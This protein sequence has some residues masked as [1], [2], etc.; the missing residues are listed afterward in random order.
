MSTSP[1]RGATVHDLVGIGFG[2][3]NLALAIAIE[4]H[5]RAAPQHALDAVFLERQ[6]RF[7]WHRGMLLD[8]ATM[9]VSFL[10]DLVTMRDPASRFS[11][12]SYLSE[13]GRLADFINRKSLFPFRIEFH[14]YLEW[15]ADQVAHL[16]RYDAEVTDV[17]P[18]RGE[19]GVDALEV[20]VG[21]Q[22]GEL[23]RVHRARNVAIAA[24]IRPSLPS[25]CTPTGRIWHNHDLLARLAELPPGEPK[26]FVVVGAGQSAAETTEYLHRHFPGCE[27]CAVFSRYGYSPSDDTAFANRIFDP[28]AVDHFFQAPDDVKRRLLE[29]HR[30]TNYSVVDPELIDDLYRRTY[31]ERVRGEQRLRMLNACHVVEVEDFAE[32]VRAVVEFLPTGERRELH[33]DALVYATGYEP[34][35]PLQLLGA[36]AAYCQRTP[37]GVLAVER[38]YRVATTEDMRCGIYVQGATEHSHGITSTLLSNTAVRVGEILSSVLAR[39]SP[40]QACS[41]PTSTSRAA[42]P[43]PVPDR[44]GGPGRTAEATTD[45]S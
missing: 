13:R 4:E 37:D 24:G 32:S 26:R 27:V 18:V 5:N 41:P 17:A 39:T 6:E 7:G 15:A 25:N 2:P 29:Y 28:E 12:L 34:V 33:A 1:S 31:Q 9:Q 43:A 42:G 38:D 22:D 10:K 8:G 3:S 40:Q 16:V 35:D 14:D 20:V 23:A 44:G 30:N 11:F 36:T 21:G 45:R 19:S